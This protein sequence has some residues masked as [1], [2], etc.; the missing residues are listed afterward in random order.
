MKKAF[1]ILGL[2]ALIGFAAQAQTTN[3]AWTFDNLAT[4]PNGSPQPSTGFGTASAV[5]LGNPYNNTN[6]ISNPDVQSLAGSS[7]D[8]SGPNSWRIRGAG[9]APNGG[10]GWSTNAPIGTQGAKFAGSTAGYYKIKV[11]FDVYATP[12]AEANLQVQYTTEGTIWQNA[13]ITSVGTLAV[14]AS[15]TDTNVPTVVGS[16][17]ILTNNGV[18]GWNN[19]ITADLTG[20][21]GVDNNPN[22]AVRMVN[23]S[24]GTNCVDT[25]GAVYNNTS[26]NW[27]FDNVIIQGVSFD[28]V[29]AWT[30]ESAGTTGFAPHPLPEFGAGTATGLGMDNNY[31]FS[32]GSVG[33]TNK[34]DTLANGAPFSSTGA[35]GQFVWRVRGAGSGSGHNGWHTLAPIG[36]QGA[37]FDVSTANYDDI[38]LSFDLFST[39]QGEAKMCVLYTTN[40]WV[41]TN[42]ASTLFYPANP[43]FIVTNSV[44]APDYSPDTVAGTYFWQNVGQNFYNNFIVDLTGVP[45]AANNSGF[46][47][48]I[49]NAAQN[50]DC[51]AYNGGSYNNSSGNWR[52]DNVTISGR[53]TGSNAPVIAYDPNATVDAPFTNTFSDNPSWRSN[54]TAIY[55]NGALLTNSA[56]TTNTAGMIV[57]TPSKSAV[58]QSSG[59]KSIV[60]YAAGYNND[61]VTQPLAAGLATKFAFTTQATAPSASGGTLIANPAMAITDKYGNGATNPYPNVTATA[62][63]GGTG[64]WTLGGATTQTAVNGV[65]AFTN[66]TATVN[67]MTNVP[68]A[69]ITFTVIGYGATFTTNSSAFTIG[70]PPAPFT[71]GNLAVLQIDTVAN[72]T[73]FSMIEIKPSASRQTTPVNIV[74]ISA[75]GTNALRMSQAGSCGRLALSSDGTLVTFVGFADGSAA[76]TDETLIQDRA[77]GTLNYNNQVTLPLRYSSISFGGSQGRSAA[78]VDNVNYLVV[79]KDGLRINNLLWSQQN[80]IVVRT[81]GANPYVATQKTAGGSPLP[82]VYSLTMTGDGASIVQANPN[83]LVTDPVAVDFYLVSTNGGASYDILYILDQTSATLGQIKKFS[84]APDNTQISGYAWTNNGAFTTGNG[85]DSIFA[86][87]NGSGGIYLYYTTGGGGTAANSVVRLTDAGGYNGSISIISSNV[88][89]TASATTSIKGF[90]FVP[91][92]T[93]NAAELIPPPLLTAQSGA[94]VSGLITVTNTPD[95]SAWR[96]AIT[97]ITV[98]G[99]ALPAAAYGTNQA[100]KLVFDPSQSSLLQSSGPKTIVISATGYSTNSIVQTLSSGAASQLVITTQ[101]KAP[102]A[103]GGL[104]TN[105]PVVVVRDLFGN[106]VTNS[107]NIAAAALQNTWT[108]GGTKTVAASSGTASYAGLTAFSTNAVIGATISFTSGALSVTSSPGFNIPA[109]ILPLMTGAASSGGKFVFAFTNATGLGFSILATNNLAVPPANWPVVGQ[110]VES[111]AG[112]GNYHFTNSAATNSIWFYRV[113]QP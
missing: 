75:T 47:F 77:V 108:L 99:T 53:F 29:T 63:V 20:I 78:T 18:T 84:W 83:N 98:N 17:A 30:F 56:Y 80:N 11:S 4:A 44:S 21:S 82:A 45:E 19:Q 16:H 40:G 48:R 54:I 89:Y 73:T 67:G 113:R 32:D 22:F 36:T 23:A 85:G 26:G 106:A 41:T 104:L 33:S 35:S 103:S 28:T 6:S 109:P 111:P 59:V 101:P 60:I 31:P 91:Q 46:A 7:T 105:Q 39:S 2:A 9:T 92:Q 25:T 64:A 65:I 43:T 49:V 102:V 51:V 94:T 12:D 10:N 112:S 57:Y 61:K 100:G 8:P 81:F 69:F 72:N 76:T 42:V 68:G 38:M 62:A 74:P 34:P 50:N 110:A 5:G 24:T 88:I 96:G 93:A 55:V 66:L 70:A 27:S 13:T 3:T 58:L 95:D 1:G 87:T 37:Q 71:R 97:G 79:D 15:N 107:A 52:Y 90:T 86:T 14:I